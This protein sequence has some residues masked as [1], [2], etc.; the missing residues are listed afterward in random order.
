M[1]E[2]SPKGSRT[3]QENEQSLSPKALN[4]NLT[5]VPITWPLSH[6]GLSSD[7][8]CPFTVPL[9][10]LGRRGVLEGQGLRLGRIPKTGWWEREESPGEA[11]RR[12]ATQLHAWAL[13][14]LHSS[15]PGPC[16][17]CFNVYFLSQP[18]ASTQGLKQA[19]A[20]GTSGT[21]AQKPPAGPATPG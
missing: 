18:V 5:L 12:T 16:H 10:A 7:G 2:R 9:W 13:S 8:Q 21:A 11:G 4:L 6:L 3:W 20:R 19:A 1:G 15:E 14:F 17:P